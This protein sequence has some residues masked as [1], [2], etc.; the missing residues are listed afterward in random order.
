MHAGSRTFE[1]YSPHCAPAL[2]YRCSQAETLELLK[3]ID[4]ADS[5]IMERQEWI[6]GESVGNAAAAAATGPTSVAEDAVDASVSAAVERSTV[7]PSRRARNIAGGG[8]VKVGHSKSLAPARVVTKAAEG[9]STVLAPLLAPQQ[10]A[11]NP[12]ISATAAAGGSGSGLDASSDGASARRSRRLADPTTVVPA[13]RAKKGPSSSS[14]SGK[15][16]FGGIVQPVV[17]NGLPMEAKPPPSQNLD[18]PNRMA[19][20][21]A[22]ASAASQDVPGTRHRQQKRT[23]TKSAGALS[24][25]QLVTRAFVTGNQHEADFT[26]EKDRAIDCA[27][28]EAVSSEPTLVGWG[29]WGGVGIRGQ[30]KREQERKNAAAAAKA[31]ARKKAASQMGG[32]SKLAK[33][34]LNERKTKGAEKFEAKTVPFEFATV[35]GSRSIYESSLRVGLGPEFNTVRGFKAKIQPSISTRLGAVVQPIKKRRGGKPMPKRRPLR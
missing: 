1:L 16:D 26:A 35:S 31:V 22:T 15:D 5:Q 2:K 24:Q 33:V 21:D 13:A 30:A 4:T 25:E 27:A 19:Q 11:G 34:L 28:E 14:A 18:V 3:Q 20:V 23:E 10:P 9:A 32:S 8:G 7:G 12:W 17:W 6:G 29:T